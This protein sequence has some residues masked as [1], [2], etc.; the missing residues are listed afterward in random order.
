MEERSSS[1]PPSIEQKGDDFKI[2]IQPEDEEALWLA[3]KNVTVTS[4]N[5]KKVLLSDICGDVKGRFLAIMVTIQL[6]NR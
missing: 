5:G 2:K 4:K 6:H 3:W 1:P